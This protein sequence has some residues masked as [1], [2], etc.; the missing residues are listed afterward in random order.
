MNQDSFDTMLNAVREFH[1]KHDFANTG[2]HDL[3]YRVALMCE[4]L[5]EIS[6]AVTKGHG[7]AQ[8]AEECADLL[9]LLLGTAIAA[10]FDLNHSF[11]L[12]MEKIQQREGRMIDGML[13]V[14]D[15][16][17]K[18]ECEPTSSTNES[19]VS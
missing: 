8:V 1:R 5:G 11:W 19:I 16:D 17:G 18:S 10:E 9:I 7:M 6:A 4:E 2:G 13:R 12:K 3:R 15:F 14:S